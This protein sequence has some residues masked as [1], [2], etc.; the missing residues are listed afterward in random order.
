MVQLFQEITWTV[1]R[2]IP[3]FWLIELPLSFRVQP[4]SIWSL[5]PSLRRFPRSPVVLFG[6]CEPFC[7]ISVMLSFASILWASELNILH[8]NVLTNSSN[9]PFGSCSHPR[10]PIYTWER[11]SLFYTSG[12]SSYG[13]NPCPIIWA[14][15]SH[16]NDGTEAG[17]ILTS[18]NICVPFIL[19]YF[20]SYFAIRA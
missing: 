11:Q 8:Y 13:S 7:P 4:A 6:S 15:F 10:M 18:M 9:M 1:L 12:D 16:I 2:M 17:R 5:D 19:P 14:S 3:K 20:S